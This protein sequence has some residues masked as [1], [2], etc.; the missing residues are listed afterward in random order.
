LQLRTRC[1]DITLIPAVGSK[2]QKL[3]LHRIDLGEICRDETMSHTD[4]S[5]VGATTDAFIL[6]ENGVRRM[7][8][9]LRSPRDRGA[10]GDISGPS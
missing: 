10:Q 5:I 9:A 1:F 7:V 2:A 6:F 8:R 3:P 4:I